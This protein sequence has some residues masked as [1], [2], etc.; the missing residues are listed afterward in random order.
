MW[1]TF[2]VL[3]FLADRDDGS[4]GVGEVA[5]ALEM[6]A[7][8]VSRLLSSL[9]AEGLVERDSPQG[10]YRVG[11]EFIRIGQRAASKHDLGA[12]AM[13]AL[14]SLGEQFNESVFFGVF[15]SA[16]RQMIRVATWTTTRPLQ[17][18]VRTHEWT[19][20][21]RGASGLAILAFL[22]DHERDTIVDEADREAGP[23]APWLA[24]AELEPFLERI[25]EQG[26]AMTKGRRVPGAVG[27][28]APVFGA[29]GRV[30]GDVI[31]TAPAERVDEHGEVALVDAVVVA[32]SA[33]T[34]SVSHLTR[35]DG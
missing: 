7:S 12:L 17:Y 9:Y 34:D 19:E 4:A 27:V 29:D 30:V 26:F 28:A 8:T 24:R 32:A 31:L 25:R 35:R 5:S 10:K 20:V 21:F 18:V 1:R 16:R 11:L 3:R 15:N 2:E 23:E 22:P 6:Q 13:P 33:M 14:S